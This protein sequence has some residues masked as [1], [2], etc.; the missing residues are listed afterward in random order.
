MTMI[1]ELAVN[2]QTIL[3]SYA[4]GKTSRVLKV[5]AA[6]VRSITF[7]DDLRNNLLSTLFNATD[8]FRFSAGEGSYITPFKIL[9]IFLQYVL[10]S[11]K[12]I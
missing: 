4:S 3:Y 7:L 5:L 8:Y 9:N 10:S 2:C 12:S 11:L 6:I 1:F